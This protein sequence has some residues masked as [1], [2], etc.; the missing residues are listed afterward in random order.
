MNK[1]LLYVF[2]WNDVFIAQIGLCPLLSGSTEKAINFT[3][4][5]AVT[6]SDMVPYM[7]YFVTSRHDSDSLGANPVYFMNSF[8]P[9][10]RLRC[11]K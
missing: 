2:N 4:A 6:Y 8:S 11:L 9:T 7:P 5:I 10:V 1:I 3:F